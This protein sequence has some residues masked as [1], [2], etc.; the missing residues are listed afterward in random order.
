[1]EI[2]R[3]ASLGKEMDL[4]GSELKK[5][6]KVEQERMKVER[7]EKEERDKR[8]AQIEIRRE[9]KEALKIQLK[10]ATIKAGGHSSQVHKQNFQPLG[11]KLPAFD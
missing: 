8:A 4:Q 3:L 6:I 10:L 7:K 1:M 2:E 5:F 11:P 9:E